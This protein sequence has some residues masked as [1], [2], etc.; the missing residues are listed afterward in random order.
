MSS[1][2]K[3][4]LEIP[5]S[6]P[7]FHY[8][9]SPYYKATHYEW[10]RKVRAFVEK[11]MMPYIDKWERQQD[12]PADLHTKAYEA[13]IYGAMYPQ[14]Y[15]GTPPKDCDPFHDLIMI[16]ELSRTGC[17]GVLWSCFYAF[18]IALPPIFEVGSQYLKDRILRNVIT[19]KK[20]MSLAIT[21]PGAGSDVANIKTTAKETDDGQHYI[22]NGE[23]YF[24]TAG[25]KAEYFTVAVRTISKEGVPHKNISL[26]VIERSF[27]GVH[28]S[29]MKTQGWLTSTTT[30]VVFRNC[31]VP[32]SHIIGQEGLGFKPLMHNFNHERF[33]FATMAN[34]YSRVC[35][36]ESI[37]Y[38][39]GRET[40]GKP[41]IKHQ[42]IRHKIGNMIKKIEATQAYI[43]EIAYKMKMKVADEQLGGPVAL[44]KVQATQTMDFCTREATQIFG[45]RGYIRGGRASKVE[46]LYREVRSMAI[47]GGSEEILVDLAVRQARL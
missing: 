29:R 45:G 41:L 37:K 35:L 5:Y 4:S 28:T 40:F 44:L 25:M 26:M 47:A 1:K 18:G 30:Y 10:Q 21:E 7:S 39:R 2:T 24:I 15:G 42:V 9:P 12:F 19:G 20:I 14:E 17:G 31:R 11:E 6:E 16:D 38:A 8:S 3:K 22:V 46:R 43:E 36:E 23:K 13:G 27:G 32:K 33:I 34:R